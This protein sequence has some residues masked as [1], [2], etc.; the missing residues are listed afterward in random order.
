[1][2]RRGVGFVF[3]NYAIFTHMTVRQNLSYGLARHAA[4][5]R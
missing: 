4:S 5:C 2:G 3:Q 1:M